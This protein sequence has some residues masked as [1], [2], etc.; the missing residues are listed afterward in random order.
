MPEMAAIFLILGK[1]VGAIILFPGTPLTLLAGAT[2]G[3]FWGSIISII[4]NT[5]G[6]TFAF[7]ISRFFLK[8]YVQDKFLTKYKNI[9]KYEK[10]FLKNGLVTVILL[11]LIPIFPFNILNYLLGVTKVSVKDYITGTFVGIIPGTIAFVY[12]GDSLRMLSAVNI[13]TAIIIILALTY[14]G[15]YYDEKFN[16]KN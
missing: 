6:A 10:R 7:L 13:I 1:I 3:T 16:K 5:L 14:V 12:F 2:L 9:E 15:K 11:R 4:G 8:N